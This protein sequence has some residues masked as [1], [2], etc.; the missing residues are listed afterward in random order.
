MTDQMHKASYEYSI[1]NFSELSIY[2]MNETRQLGK[3][4]KKLLSKLLI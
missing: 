3:V 1:R 2:N 4:L